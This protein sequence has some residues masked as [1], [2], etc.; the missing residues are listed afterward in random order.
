MVQRDD[1]PREVNLMLGHKNPPPEWQRM[2]I[3]DVCQA[4]GLGRSTI[5]KLMGLGQFPK[6]CALSPR[7]V[8]WNAAEIKA[9]L[10]SKAEGTPHAA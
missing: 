3:M 5:Y 7:V 9:W 8:V 6:N 4:T 1:N 10:E 2:R